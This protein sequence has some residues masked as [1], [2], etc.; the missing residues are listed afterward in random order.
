MYCL[1]RKGPS[2][3]TL[4]WVA[5]QASGSQ[6]PQSDG[7]LLAVR[8]G[9]WVWAPPPR[10]LRQFRPQVEFRGVLSHPKPPLFFPANSCP[11][12]QLPKL[13]ER[14]PAPSLSGLWGQP[15]HP[16]LTL[17]KGI[18]LGHVLWFVLFRLLCRMADKTTR[19]AGAPRMEFP[20]A[21]P[22]HPV[23]RFWKCLGMLWLTASEVS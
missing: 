20:R 17:L 16:A 12:S 5:C 22:A 19:Q 6:G 4:W 8:P 1:Y 2:G 9:R 23:R 15:P 13:A 18:S 14:T 7:Q 10:P 21:E 3:E 11:H